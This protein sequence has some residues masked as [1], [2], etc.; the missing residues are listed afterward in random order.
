MTKN[1]NKISIVGAGQVG[2]ATAQ[3]LARENFC[4]EIAL[5][6][7]KEG[8]PQGAALD[9][10]HAI[11]LYE[12]DTAIYGYHDYAALCDSH[13]VVVTAGYPRKPGM[14]RADL[15][16]T[17]KP[18]IEEV[19]ANIVKYAPHAFIIVITNP[20]DVLTYYA[21]R[22]SGWDRN[23]IIGLSCVLDS[24]RMVSLIA[25]KTGCS[26]KEIS[27]L[28]IGG[29]GDSMV[30]LPRFSRINGIPLDVFLTKQ[31]VAEIIRATRQAGSEI[32]ALKGTSGYVAAAA[33]VVT[34]LDAIINNRNHI[35]PCVA[36]LAGEYA[37]ENMALG[38]PALIGGE[39]VQKIIELPLNEEETTA[40][41]RSAA[42]VREILQCGN[43]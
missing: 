23:R 22:A 16:D 42:E 14:S 7:R 13:V 17:N 41:L 29:H 43:V 19:V 30:P 6:G 3:M 25:H 5:I 10:R 24:A 31:D 35:L 32:V 36:V 27:A 18:I 39:G 9:I 37:L 2:Q 21:W 8:V 34:M 33:S 4:N 12:S 1:G 26:P 28:V 15:L 11:P 38:V 40:F 20:V